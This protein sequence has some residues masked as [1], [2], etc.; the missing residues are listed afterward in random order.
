[1]R[2]QLEVT[3][4]L[5]CKVNLTVLLLVFRETPCCAEVVVCMHG[6]GVFMICGLE[7][8]PLPLAPPTGNRKNKAGSRDRD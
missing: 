1:M 6:N 3:E 7:V 8:F 4:M 5:E 2:S